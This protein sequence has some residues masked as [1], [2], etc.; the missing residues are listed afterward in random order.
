M[1]LKVEDSSLS[2]IKGAVIVH[3]REHLEREGTLDAVRSH[4]PREWAA[5]LD[6]SVF[7]TDW[8]D[9]RAFGALAYA[10]A[11]HRSTEFV[12]ETMH[13]ITRTRSV[14]RVQP[15][16]SG[17]ARLFGLT[18]QT[19]LSRA[20]LINQATVR[21]VD[22]Q[23]TSLSATAGTL[24]LRFGSNVD[25]KAPW[26][27]VSTATMSAWAGTLQTVFDVCSVEGRATPL[28]AG[29]DAIELSFAWS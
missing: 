23:W 1:S 14:P 28:R 10:L 22:A 6:A 18:P 24:A 25:A 7:A 4:L 12:F 29:N 3:L 9:L 2:A 16:I 15:I 20:N 21:N 5:T 19:L 26:S 27:L 17:V 11:Q 8:I 13:T